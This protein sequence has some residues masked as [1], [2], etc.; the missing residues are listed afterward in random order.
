MHK[1]FLGSFLIVFLIAVAAFGLR[2]GTA[3]QDTTTEGHPLVGTWLADTDQES[4]D[5]ALDTFVFSADGTFFQSE[6]GGGSVLG[7]WEATGDR[8]AT[9][10]AVGAEADENGTNVGS[11]WIRASI[12]V[13]EDGNSFTAEYTIEFVQP[14]GAASGEA[15][16][17]IATGDR[18]VVEAPGT[19]TVTFEE[20]F[21]AFDGQPEATPEP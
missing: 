4:P 17:G 1:K 13:S 16:P 3:A 9:L 18:L 15:G 8:T 21:G 2:S 6:A 7:A 14:D 20:L 5:N 10:T 11:I 19:P 12:E